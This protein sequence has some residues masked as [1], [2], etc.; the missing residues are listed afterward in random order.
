MKGSVF[1]WRIKPLKLGYILTIISKLC[2]PKR[3]V[4]FATFLIT[5]LQKIAMLAFNHI[6]SMLS[7]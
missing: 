5:S 4:V 2:S 6:I 3:S 7:L 1:V